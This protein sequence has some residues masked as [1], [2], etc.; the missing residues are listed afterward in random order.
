MATPFTRGGKNQIPDTKTLLVNCLVDF[1]FKMIK[2]YI[3]NVQVLR[4]EAFRYLT[5]FHVLTKWVGNADR[6]FILGTI[7]H[8]ITP[9]R[10]LE[11]N[12]INKCLTPLPL[13]LS[14]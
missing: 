8:R 6:S 2:I 14:V 3:H 9:S 4:D 12:F 10:G 11:S 7:Y 13:D 1:D 5:K